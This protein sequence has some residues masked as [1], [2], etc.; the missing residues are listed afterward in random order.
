MISWLELTSWKNTSQTPL[1]LHASWRALNLST[2]WNHTTRRWKF[3]CKKKLDKEDGRW[4][5]VKEILG[6][7]IN[8]A[9]YTIQ[10]PPDKVDKVL[11]HLNK[12]KKFKTKIPR[13]ALDQLAGSL[14]HAS[15]GI[16]GGAGLFSPIQQGLVGN[17][18][19][20]KVTANLKQCFQDWGAIIKHM[21][22]QSTHIL[23][24]VK[25]LPH[26][27]GFSNSC[28]IGTRGVRSS[29][30]VI[31]IPVLWSLKWPQDIQDCFC[32]GILTFNDLKLVGMVIHWLVLECLAPTLWFK[33]AALFCDNSSAVSWAHKL[34]ESL[35]LIARRLLRF[36][37][38]R[39]HAW[40][41]SHITS[42]SIE[43]NILWPIFSHVPFAMENILTLKTI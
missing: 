27:V 21:V 29:R 10:L 43:G 32:A 11:H 22:G 7:T 2:T 17:K 20:I 31:I 33:H 37:G 41:S 39:I 40:Q 34:Q 13:K 26:Y 36:L 4:E 15:F 14:E 18:Q 35:S 42:L 9:T 6:W 5:E 25:G 8:G 28:G 30:T 12:I 3:N 1:T 24:I 16:L 38:I 23:Q 19:W